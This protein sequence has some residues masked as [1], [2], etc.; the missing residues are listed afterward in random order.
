MTYIYKLQINFS[1]YKDDKLSFKMYDYKSRTQDMQFMK[2]F[3]FQTPLMSVRA[4]RAA[5]Q[6]LSRHSSRSATISNISL[7]WHTTFRWNCIV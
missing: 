2:C 5:A 3:F 1:T 7:G 6:K 4:A